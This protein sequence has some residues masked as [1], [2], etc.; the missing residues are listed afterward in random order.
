MLS[1]SAHRKIL[2][3]AE[4]SED[5]ELV[6]VPLEQGACRGFKTPVQITLCLLIGRRRRLL[7][8]KKR[9]TMLSIGLDSLSTPIRPL[10]TLG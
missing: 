1:R 2:A 5:P 4:C 7:E 8:T 9:T 6:K 3:Y 10:Y